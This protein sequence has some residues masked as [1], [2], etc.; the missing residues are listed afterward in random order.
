MKNKSFI[1]LIITILLV[2]TSCNINSGGPGTEPGEKG[3]LTVFS[4]GK[5]S[6]TIITAEGASA[7]VL[8]L[9]NGLRDLSGATPAILTDKSNETAHEIIVGETSRDDTAQYAKRLRETATVSAFHYIVAEKGGKLVIISDADEGYI[10]ALDHIK[11]TYINGGDLIVPIDT[12]DFNTV[13]WDDYFA[14]DRY[15]S[16]LLAEAEKNRFDEGNKLLSN[17]MNRY[18]DNN[19]SNIMTVE[20]ATEQYK[21]MAANFNTADFG[22]YTAQTFI[23][24]NK[25]NKPTVTPGA[26]HPR[27]LFTENEKSI[28]KI[29][30]NLN[31]E[32]NSAAYEKYIAL[33]DSPCDGKFKTLSGNM[34]HNYDADMVS[35]IEAKAFRFAMERNKEKYPN[36][37]DDPAAIYGYEAIY[38]VKNAILTIN[39]PHTV[40]DWCR[41]YGFL[42][43]VSACVYDWCY[44]L[45]TEEDKTQLINGA[46]NL[47]GVHL[48]MV[49]YAGSANKVPIEQGAAYG[50]GAE[51]QLLVD[52]L[53]FAIACYD[54]A[55][56]I[57]NFV[58]GRIFDEYTAM[59]NYLFASGSHWE[60]SMYGGVRSA[61]TIMSNI[62][63]NRMTDGEVTPFEDLQR[64]AITSTF[65]V[66]PDGQRYRI[67]DLD[68][69]YSEF[70]PSVWSIVCFYAANLYGDSYL[71]DFAYDSLKEFNYFKIGVAGLTPVQFLA[72]ND[73][74]ISHIYE[75]EAPLVCTVNYPTTSLFAKSANDDKD[76]F[77]VYMTMP[78]SFQASH[79]HMECGSFQIF[80]KGA[81]AS[82]SG[83]Y[84]GWG[85][86]HHLGYSMQTIASNSILVYNPNLYGT[87]NSYRQNLIYTGG[88]SVAKEGELPNTLSQL[89]AHERLGQ[90]TSLGVANVEKNG[91][92][93]Y[94]YMG[95]DM[96]EAYDEE[97]VDEVTRY[98]FSVATGDESCPLVFMTFDRITSDDASYHKSA[99]IHVQEEPTVKDGFA[100][101]TNTKGTNNGKLVVQTV[102][103]ET[104]YTVIGGE[105]EEFWIPGVDAEGNYSL[106]EGKNLPSGKTLVEGSLAEYGWGRIEISPKTAE[107]TNHMLTVMYATDAT[108]N[109][110]L[111]KAEDISSENLAGAM[112]FGKAVLFSKNEKLLTKESSFTINES[113]ECYIAGVCA[114]EWTVTNGTSTLTLEVAEGTNLLHFEAKEAGTYT[115]KPAN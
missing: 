46:V 27:V 24:A 32:Q 35:K 76:A 48:E 38:A 59:Q 94:S 50:H 39:V 91:E 4:G 74:E 70:S 58:A 15:N 1:F 49:C 5:T 40:G 112:I 3:D 43:Y 107:K 14:S 28:G 53:S 64:A 23:S 10:Y 37:E 55:P 86:E 103:D 111:E 36:A 92:Y 63:F 82:D 9:S 115:I 42:M 113:G 52:Y 97:T 7:E 104:E 98:M 25:Y 11:A 8:E 65:Y 87:H 106:A 114:G 99:L 69:N 60:G 2:L 44:D 13:I 79:A 102:G 81:L 83:A 72:T 80:Y 17:E 29:R 57:Y 105:G 31:S 109:A 110:S 88:Q 96:T 51:D 101:I 47:L 22:E 93:L 18:D 108:N 20:Q 85:S 56:E 90:C 100:V 75:G 77:S 95:G 34:S 89:L 71:K 62:L 12:Y 21:N 33:A 30:E 41:T 19:G 61:A 66:R 84:A 45:L 78:E 68:E 6:Y 67:G 26:S 16:I 73:P 54:E